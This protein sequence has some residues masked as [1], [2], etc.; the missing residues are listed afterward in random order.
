MDAPTVEA[1]RHFIQDHWPEFL[2]DE[3][4]Q[5]PELLAGSP[6]E[7][8]FILPKPDHHYVYHPVFSKD[9]KFLLTGLTRTREETEP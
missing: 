6:D 8:L 4:F 1:F 3:V 9:G 5:A 2:Q 7:H